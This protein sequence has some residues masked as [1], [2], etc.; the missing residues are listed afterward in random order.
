[1]TDILN[2]MNHIKSSCIAVLFCVFF[3]NSV[4]FS[5]QRNEILIA[6][7][8]SANYGL[9]MATGDAFGTGPAHGT[10]NNQQAV[11]GYTGIGLVNTFRNGD[12]ST[13]TLTSPEFIIERRFITFLIGGGK[14]EGLTCIDL[15]VDGKVVCTSTG[16]D[17]ERLDVGEWDVSRLEGKSA[18]IRIVDN[19]TGGWGHINIDQIVQRDSSITAIFKHTENLRIWNRIWENQQAQKNIPFIIPLHFRFIATNRTNANGGFEPKNGT[20]QD[21]LAAGYDVTMDV[22]VGS[23][24]Q[25]QITL[26][27]AVV[28]WVRETQLLNGT[29]LIPLQNGKIRLRGLTYSSSVSFYDPNGVAC[30]V[31]SDVVNVQNPEL[32]IRSLGG[33]AIIDRIEIYGLR[34][35]EPTPEESRLAALA[36]TDKRIF[37]KS[38][39]Y[40]VYGGSVV[41][42]IYGL[43][44]AY[45]PERNTIVSPTRVT[46]SFR[47]DLDAWRPWLLGRVIDHQTIWHPNAEISRFPEIKTGWPTVDAACGVAL[48]V[49]QRCGDGEFA[50]NSGEVGLWEAGF[51]WG[52]SSGFGIWLRD[53]THVALRAGNLI[54]PDVAGL[55]LRSTAVGGIDNGSDGVA[56]PIIGLWDNYL[57]TGNAGPIQAVWGNLKAQIIK[58]DAQ[59]DAN[60]G[61]IKAAQSTSND[62]FPEPE[63]GGFALGT[64]TYFM[65]AYRAMVDM[66]RMMKESES[67]ITA[68]EARYQLLAGNIRTLY[69]KETAGIFTTGPV[70][71]TGYTNN[72]WESSGQEMAI[73]P[74]FNIASPAQ[75]RKV[76]DNLPNIAMNE[77]GVNVF[78]YRNETNHF[79]NAAWVAWTAGM[80]AAAGREGRLDILQQLIG[81]QVR[82]AVMNKTFFEVIDYKSGRAW[83]WP[84][85]LWQATGFLSYFYF[86]V[87]GMEYNI[88]GLTLYP[89]VPESLANIEISNFRYRESILNIVVKGWG[90][91][92]VVNLDGVRVTKIPTDLQGNHLIEIVMNDPVSKVTF[93]NSDEINVYPNP[94]NDIIHV[95]NV[96]KGKSISICD[97][98]GRLV[99]TVDNPNT[100]INIAQL[101]KGPYFIKI[102]NIPGVDIV[103]LF[104]KN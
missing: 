11:T 32:N 42:S 104:M 83:R 85:Q 53:A 30:S 72:N 45:V 5:Q 3:G 35:T 51:F 43:P 77:F 67:L 64:E 95:S 25:L 22:S 75:R 28:N 14:H 47:D 54:D 60:K 57:V 1:M 41:D 37:Y 17:N 98:Q 33:A 79:C 23:A 100:S 18:K 50:R 62:N 39:S 96:T 27:G 66:G 26:C 13:G 24:T 76:L 69:W 84:G 59:F 89:A 90:T 103:K 48:D 71:S 74:R 92:G 20:D 58:L 31:E 80:A 97:I 101:S 87:L 16:P 81:Q 8:E 99:K 15:L 6:D 10:L 55:T 36:D 49:L 68:W 40:T 86:G 38:K 2:I 78:P 102:Q 12:L 19:V 63:A 56:M 73:W 29:I 88:D 34:S 93:T 46:E 70:G 82:N 91:N 61:L 94:A 7:F 52:K 65:Q 4:A 21:I 44:A 9:W